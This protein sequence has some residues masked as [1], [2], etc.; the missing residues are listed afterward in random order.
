MRELRLWRR[1]LR[2]LCRN[3]DI[4]FLQ[5]DGNGPLELAQQY[6][7]SAGGLPAMAYAGLPCR[8]V[9]PRSRATDSAAAVILRPTSL[10]THQW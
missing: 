10:K 1:V 6:V 7:T 3:H 5:H 9:V 8:R 4:P 2:T